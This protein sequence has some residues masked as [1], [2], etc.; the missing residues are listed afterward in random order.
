MY[1]ILC[2]LDTTSINKSLHTRP[3]SAPT[4]S[5]SSVTPT[6]HVGTLQMTLPQNSTAILI[7][8]SHDMKPFRNLRVHIFRTVTP[9]TEV[10]EHM[11]GKLN[12]NVVLWGIHT[13]ITSLP[14]TS[15]IQVKNTSVIN[16]V[17]QQSSAFILQNLAV[18]SKDML[19][20]GNI[21]SLLNGG[22]DFIDCVVRLYVQIHYLAGLELDEY[23]PSVVDVS[24]C[25]FADTENNVHYRETGDF[26]LR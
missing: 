15:R 21:R 17:A 11:W 10:G 7:I 19:P 18:E 22:L 25:M 13:G 4:D 9:M 5:F 20:V 14:P 26:R 2:G 8:H 1:K 6:S 23:L 24:N 16:I 12:R 3:P